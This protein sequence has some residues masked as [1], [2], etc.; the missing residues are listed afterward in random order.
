MW[1]E[2]RDQ[3][4]ERGRRRVGR[5]EEVAVESSEKHCFVS[6]LFFG[7]T[8]FLLFFFP[9]SVFEFSRA[10]CHWTH[11]CSPLVWS[12]EFRAGSQRR[13]STHAQS[14]FHRRRPPPTNVC[15][16]VA[17]FAPAFRVF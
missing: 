15:C 14:F 11:R 5:G 9:P 8:F 16:V 10:R 1:S 3:R 13:E 7:K 2:F 6:L 12:Q 4:R 17:A